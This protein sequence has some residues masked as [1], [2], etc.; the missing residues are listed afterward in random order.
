MLKCYLALACLAL[1]MAAATA[2]HAADI[3]PAAATFPV[4]AAFP[5]LASPAQIESARAIAAAF[6]EHFIYRSG[7]DHEW[8]VLPDS[9]P[10][11]NCSNYV[12][13]LRAKFV[14][15]A[16]I[17]FFATHEVIVHDEFDPPIY[18]NGR[19]RPQNHV[20]LEIDASNGVFYADNKGD[21][22]GYRFYAAEDFPS[23]YRVIS[24]S[25]L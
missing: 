11:G 10:Y 13:T 20:V 22:W 14:A 5:I 12:A 7:F 18:L 17:P 4:P 15:L 16:G 19:V 21:D 3:A 25:V 9:A 6:D 2:T 23:R 24:R 8:E 1:T